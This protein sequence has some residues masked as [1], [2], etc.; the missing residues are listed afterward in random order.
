MRFY[1]FVS[2][3]VIALILDV[4]LLG[5]GTGSPVART[6]PPAL[7]AAAAPSAT[8]TATSIPPTHTAV[9]P[10]ATPTFTP[11][12]TPTFTPSPT[13][14]F[15]PSPTATPLPQL[16]AANNAAF[17]PRDRAV[18]ANIRLAL[19]HY[20][21]ALTHV[22][23]PPGGVFSFNSTLGVNPPA[24]PWKDVVVRPTDAPAPPPAEPA[25]DA[26]PDA[27]AP[28][29][30]PPAALQRI[31]GGGLCDLASRYVMAARPLL[32][33]R[34]FRF[35]NHYY[36][37]GVR[38]SGVPIRDSVSIWAVGGGAGEHDLLI[39]NVTDHWLEFRVVRDGEKIT[40][41]AGLWDGVPP[42]W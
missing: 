3:L 8:P 10:T 31:E 27:P 35:V 11:S 4:V 25:P 5:L 7:A 40:V 19:S 41:Y 24:L 30:P 33:A 32:P 2:L 22:V 14:T 18:R 38:M 6:A 37:N 42:D 9:P 39:T 13:P 12:P 1:G 28:A 16:I 23:L 34:A 21:G 17:T 15:T 20:F 26:P 36:S 29:A